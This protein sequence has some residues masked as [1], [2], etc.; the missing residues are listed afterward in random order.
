VLTGRRLFLG[1]LRAVELGVRGLLRGFGL[2]VGK[3]SKGAYEA[4][5]RALVTG[6]LILEPV[7]EAMLRARASLLDECNKLHHM[8]LRIVRHDAVCQRLMSVLASARWL[9]LPIRRAWT[10]RRDSAS[11]EMSAPILA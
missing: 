1:K 9:R 2:K 11:P 4:C 10:I 7:A 8:L 3:V 5:I 6:H